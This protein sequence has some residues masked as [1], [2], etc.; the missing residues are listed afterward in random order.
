NTSFSLFAIGT[1]KGVYLTGAKWNLINQE[2]KPGTQGLHNVV[3]E[4]C[5]EI[6]YSSGRLLLFLDR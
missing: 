6:K 3:V 5:L 1:V 4:N 2:L